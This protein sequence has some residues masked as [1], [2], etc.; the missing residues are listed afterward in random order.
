M[1]TA[2]ERRRTLRAAM[3]APGIVVAP[4]AYDPLS[5]MLVAEAGFPAVHVSGSGVARSWGF[6]DVG[7]TSGTEMVGIHEH[8][9]DAV[10]V[11]VVGDAEKG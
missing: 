11:P 10:D 6:A 4:S 8:I 3:Q 2:S 5:A 1:A 9:V 7:L